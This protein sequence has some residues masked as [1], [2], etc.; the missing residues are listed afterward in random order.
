MYVC[1]KGYVDMYGIFLKSTSHT[2]ILYLL[3]SAIA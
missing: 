2:N 1:Q 3:N